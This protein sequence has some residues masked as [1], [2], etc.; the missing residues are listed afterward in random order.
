MKTVLSLC[1]WLLALP[2][3]AIPLD[4]LP[5]PRPTHW[6]LDTTRTL[7]PQEIARLEAE[8]AAAKARTGGEIAVVVV[9]STDGRPAHDYATALANRWLLGDQAKRNGVLVLL[10]VADR[11]AEIALGKGIDGERERTIARDLLERD[12]AP[13]FRQGDWAGGLLAGVRG[14]AGRILPGSGEPSRR[15]PKGP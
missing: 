3:S 5:S 15:R 9:D 13:R 7:R 11:R 1:A 2:L 12:M 10:A 6:V 4:R 14:A 8:A